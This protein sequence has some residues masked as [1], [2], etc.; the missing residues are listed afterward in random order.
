[1]VAVVLGLVMWSLTAS[2][3]PPQTARAGRDASVSASVSTRDGTKTVTPP[4]AKTA[5][6][7]KE[8]G[9][10]L[11][12]PHPSGK[13]VKPPAQASD[14]HDS[15]AVENQTKPAGPQEEP[16]SQAE[17]VPE[18]ASESKAEPKPELTPAPK[19]DDEQPK[20]QPV[21]STALQQATAS[22]VEEVYKLADARKPE[23]QIKRAKDL[24][25]M[26]QEATKPEEQFVLLR[27]AAELA[28]D[29]GDTALM[30][31]MVN[32][33]GER[34]ELDALNVKAKLLAKLAAKANDAERIKSLVEG[35]DALID[36]AVAEDRFD[37]ALDWVNAVSRLCQKR[38]GA[39][40]RKQVLLRRK[41]IQTS[42]QEAKKVGQALEA[43][44][45]NPQDA[46]ANLTV[47][48]L[49]CFTKGDWAKGLS[50]LAKGSDENLKM[51]ALQESNSPPSDTEGE[52]KLADAW[53][54][55]AQAV[56]GKV[57][58]AILLHA[59]MWYQRA[60]VTLP[61]GLVKARVAKRLEEIAALGR[62]PNG[63]GHLSRTTAA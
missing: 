24:A 37:L 4:D 41:A 57:R 48:K 23:E 28:G 51:L 1:M 40:F 31:Q 27:K 18:A 5:T 39:P 25:N 38:E 9:K 7:R 49:Y 35:S 55:I 6:A 34:F 12:P 17:P 43:A 54:N 22:Q 52:V 53:W 30:F 44:R 45:A 3:N 16:G 13:V 60:Q 20:R 63:F 59:G 50:Y 33:L 8:Q 61:V 29:A 11:S 19:A 2:R 42:Q 46:E 21:P 26:A 47:G 32:R 62:G 58:G 10:A 56:K 36:Q 15:N 14:V